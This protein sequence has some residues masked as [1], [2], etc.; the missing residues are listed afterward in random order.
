MFRKLNRRAPAM[1]PRPATSSGDVGL[2]CCARVDPRN[3]EAMPFKVSGTH[4][5]TAF[6]THHSMCIGRT[7][8]ATNGWS[9]DQ[10]TLPLRASYNGTDR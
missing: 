3:A 6:P 4:E 2:P 10:S 9:G 5:H 1:F 7:S 8:V